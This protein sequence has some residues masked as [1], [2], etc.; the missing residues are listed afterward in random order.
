MTS[1]AIGISLTADGP[2]MVTRSSQVGGPAGPFEPANGRRARRVWR[3]R[4]GVHDPVQ[5]PEAGRVIGDAE[6]PRDAESELDPQI[7]VQGSASRTRVHHQ[8]RLVGSR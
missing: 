3:Q 1:L 5:D 6:R 2:R 7:R 4:D 8:A